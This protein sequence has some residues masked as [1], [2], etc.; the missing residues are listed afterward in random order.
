[1][2][3]AGYVTDVL[4][5]LNSSSRCGSCEATASS[6]FLY[7]YSRQLCLRNTYPYLRVTIRSNGGF[8]IVALQA[9]GSSGGVFGQITLGERGLPHSDAD[10]SQGPN[11]LRSKNNP[12][13]L[14]GSDT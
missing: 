10:A 11:I 13:F 9:R 6:L 3:R 14:W 8:V 2:V 1:M 5:V 12:P 4:V 7:Q